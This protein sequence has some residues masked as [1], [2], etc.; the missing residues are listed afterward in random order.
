M[1][2]LSEF[3]QWLGALFWPCRFSI[4]QHYKASFTAQLAKHRNPGIFC[5]I[6]N[7]GPEKNGTYSLY[8][9]RLR[10]RAVLE[11]IGFEWWTC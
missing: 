1:C 5:F 11:A 3:C 8:V 6:F 9:D 4:A 2:L 7:V 10:N